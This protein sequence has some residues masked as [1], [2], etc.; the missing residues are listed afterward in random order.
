MYSSISL[1]RH[2]VVNRGFSQKSI[3]KATSVNPDELVRYEPSHLDLH[4]CKDIC[5]HQ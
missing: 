4:V 1:F 5:T 2:I 3:T